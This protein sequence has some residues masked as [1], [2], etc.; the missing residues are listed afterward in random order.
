MSLKLCSCTL[1]DMT[2]LRLS[3]LLISS[4]I[5]HR[6]AITSKFGGVKQRSTAAGG[7]AARS[8]AGPAV[9]GAEQHVEA[10]PDHVGDVRVPRETR[11]VVA[12]QSTQLAAAECRQAAEFSRCSTCVQLAL[13]DQPVQPRRHLLAAPLQRICVHREIH[14]M[15]H[16]YI[17]L[18]NRLIL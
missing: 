11:D 6:A 14:Y 8:A 16:I 15:Q 5:K 1:H 7:A 9:G 10:R 3:L 12:T 4:H 17:A 13:S 2:I 18:Y